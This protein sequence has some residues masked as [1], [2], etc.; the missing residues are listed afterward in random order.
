MYLLG[1]IN[2]GKLQVQEQATDKSLVQCSGGRAK[3]LLRNTI[4]LVVVLAVFYYC[5]LLYL[6]R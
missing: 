1:H 2:L 6:K 5:H 4:S 3:H